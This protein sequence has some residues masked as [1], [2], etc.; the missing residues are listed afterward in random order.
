MK[1][2]DR[3]NRSQCRTKL[4][5]IATSYSTG[6]HSRTGKSAEIMY[7]STYYLDG[8]EYYFKAKLTNGAPQPQMQE[9]LDI[10]ETLY[11]LKK[12]KSDNRVVISHERLT[13]MMQNL[14]RSED[15]LNVN[16]SLHST[17]LKDSFNALTGIRY[18]TNFI[19][20]KID[21]LKTYLKV[22][23][24]QII[25][26]FR[27]YLQGNKLF[28]EINFTQ[29]YVDL[30]LN[31][32][33]RQQYNSSILN[34][35]ESRI[36]RNAAMLFRNKTYSQGWYQRKVDGLASELWP[37][38]KVSRSEINDFLDKYQD[39]FKK[40]TNSTLHLV[41]QVKDGVDI[42]NRYKIIAKP[43]WMIYERKEAEKI[44][45]DMLIEKRL[46]K[47]IFHNL[48][49][50]FNDGNRVIR[51]IRFIKFLEQ[52]HNL[53]HMSEKKRKKYFLDLFSDQKLIEMM[54]DILQKNHLKFEDKDLF[55]DYLQN[56][57][58]ERLIYML[59]KNNE[60][61][62]VEAVQMG[63]MFKRSPDETTRIMCIDRIVRH[64]GHFPYIINTLSH[65]EMYNRVRDILPKID[66]PPEE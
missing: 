19:P 38:Q 21:K 24:L 56:Q 64:I 39:Y 57:S 51:Y 28:Y 43:F 40:S 52:R 9:V 15:Q 61:Q 62:V 48:L 37:N 32:F 14:L 13:D 41:N 29:N 34:D 31:Q 26:H 18:D 35:C 53:E 25:D 27:S 54:D 50:V 63:D 45:K 10:C 16:Y 58:N 11:L 55:V 5:F 47:P 2:L 20:G 3:F 66:P 59:P 36:A 7:K 23:G 42:N 4:P 12:D 22:K 65:Q 49:D 44:L 46:H 30:C 1:T 17:R 33:N 6:L 8:N 60:K